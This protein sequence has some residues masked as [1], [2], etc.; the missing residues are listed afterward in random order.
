MDHTWLR[1]LRASSVRA[2]MQTSNTS[3]HAA[4]LV[5]QLVNYNLSIN[6]C[7]TALQQR[8]NMKEA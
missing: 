3:E 6:N 7:H 1:W 8:G 2:C 5:C 4:I